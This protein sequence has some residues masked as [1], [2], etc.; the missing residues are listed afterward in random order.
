MSLPS[1]V[2]QLKT[3]IKPQTTTSQSPPQDS[4]KRLYL[5]GLRGV[6][7]VCGIATV[8][9]QTFVPALAWKD[10]DGPEYQ[11]A[12]RIIFSPV[13]WDEHLLTSFFFILSGYAVALRFLSDPTPANF[14]G[15]IIRRVVRLVVAVGLASGIS[16]AV[17]AGQGTTYI[18][19]FIAT[20][21]NNQINAP[22][23]PENGLVALNAIFNIFWVV[24][25]YYN[26]AAN[27]FWPTQTIW[28]LS[29]IFSQSWTTYFLMVI[30]PYT[31]PGWHTGALSLFALGS[32]WVCS[33]GWY[34]AAALLL[35]DYTTNSQLRLRLEEGIALN[36]KLD[37]KLP[38]T[39]LAAAMTIAGFAMKYTWAA[40][41]QF[42]N[43]EL[44][45]RPF[46]HLSERTNIAE[47]AASGPYARVDN[48][49]VIMGVLLLAE[50]CVP[51]KHWLSVKPL[52]VL[53]KRS[54]SKS[55]VFHSVRMAPLTKVKVSSSPKA[56]SSGLLASSFT[57]T[58]TRT[59]VWIHHSPSLQSLL[60]AS[61]PQ[62]SAPRSSIVWSMYR[63]SGLRRRRLP[64]FCVNNFWVQARLG[65]HIWRS[66]IVEE[67]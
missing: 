29:L 39:L 55:G 2:S 17:F 27:A 7:A 19:R 14:A 47:Y 11:N 1:V 21:P 34:S 10:A 45:L 37:W 56:S 36:K 60:L 13:F 65:R 57:F 38:Y 16:S 26:Q 12:L 63:A 44:V 8:F 24:T 20:L 43:K 9:F 31:R 59:A 6:L 61:S 32:F 67:P 54:L 33:W 25:D 46:L 28:N 5:Y 52:V 49:L 23:V 53:G 4:D 50:A 22:I 30:L 48:F 66:E 40:L 58:C 41:P 64:G 15:S 18:D 35:A 3:W 51:V 62:A 42:Y